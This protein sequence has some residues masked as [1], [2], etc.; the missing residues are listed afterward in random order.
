MGS[1]KIV[2]KASSSSSSRQAVT[3]SLPINSGINPYLIKS[4]GLTFLIVSA[5]LLDSSFLVT[6]ASKPI[7]FSSERLLMISSSPEKA[8]P[9][10]NNIFDV[11]T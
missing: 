10:I 8:P 5:A 11:S 1:V 4:S 7:P 6:D 3:G 9:Q 2:T